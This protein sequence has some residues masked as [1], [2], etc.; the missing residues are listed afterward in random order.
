M[1][2][3]ARRQA[4]AIP[5]ENRRAVV[6]VARSGTWHSR[7][8]CGVRRVEGS[9]TE[10][11]RRFPKTVFR[12]A[13][14]GHRLRSAQR[15]VKVRC[16]HECVWQ[17]LDFRRCCYPVEQ[18]LHD[19]PGHHPFLRCARARCPKCPA[20]A[21]RRFYSPTVQ[22]CYAGLRL[23]QRFCRLG[24]FATWHDGLRR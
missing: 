2:E 3:P 7:G 10:R 17:L 5:P 18:C 4:R 14:G 13:H 21:P 9:V 16:S 1:A 24:G 15:V 12:P 8:A 22:R 19:R 6:G 23:L 20:F 11:V